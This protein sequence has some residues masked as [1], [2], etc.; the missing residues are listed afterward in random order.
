MFPEYKYNFAYSPYFELNHEKYLRME[1]CAWYTPVSE[2]MK[3]ITNKSEYRL[4][5]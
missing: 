3:K 2:N 5:Y 4:I 1:N